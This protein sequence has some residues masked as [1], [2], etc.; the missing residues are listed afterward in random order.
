MY[1]LKKVIDLKGKNN[2]YLLGFSGKMLGLGFDELETTIKEKYP[3][4]AGQM[5]DLRQGY[6]ECA[7]VCFKLD[8]PNGATS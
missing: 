3:K 5:E 2:I 7:E 4:L 1:D 6:S 8:T